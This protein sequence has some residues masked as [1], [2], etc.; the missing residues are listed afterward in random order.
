VHVLEE[1]GN[2]SLLLMNVRTRRLTVG[3]VKQQL[4]VDTEPGF[5]SRFERIAAR[6]QLTAAELRDLFDGALEIHRGCYP[7]H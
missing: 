6:M 1:D 7:D 4:Y 3:R 2:K 5:A